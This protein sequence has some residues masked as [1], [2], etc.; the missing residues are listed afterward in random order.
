MKQATGDKHEIN[1]TVF[2]P[3]NRR[4]LTEQKKVLL[5]MASSGSSE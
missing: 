4:K 3:G 1:E 2:N 5:E